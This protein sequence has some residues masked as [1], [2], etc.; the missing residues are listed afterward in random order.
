MDLIT[1]LATQLTY[2][3]LIDEIYGISNGT[4]Q[5]PIKM[6]SQN[7]DNLASSAADGKKQIM[8][9]SAD[10]L[11]SELRDKNFRAVGPVLSKQ[12][13]L[14]SSQLDDKHTEKTIQ[15]IQQFVARLPGMLEDKQALAMHTTIAEHIKDKTG[16]DTFLDNLQTEQEFLNC[17][18]VDKASNHIEDLIAQK[19]P[20]DKVLRLICLQ[21]LAG[22]GLKQKLLEYYIRELVQVYGLE[23]YLS[24]VN[25]E[26]IGLLKA[27]SGTR[28]YTVLRKVIQP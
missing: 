9:N 12:A 25:L 1:P 3:G 22:S 21:C 15:E 6:F 5:F 24:I 7:D 8:L 28:Q 2:E 23:T 18:E 26:K 20:L 10:K 14:I 11:Y 27:Q 17:I 16:T 4:C 19:A 13:R